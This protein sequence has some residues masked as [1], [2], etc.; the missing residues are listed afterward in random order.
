M[1]GEAG[2]PIDTNYKW[3]MLAQLWLTYFAFGMIGSSIPPLITPIIR[4]LTLSLSQMGIIL[5]TTHLI[6]IPMAILIGLL[7][8]RVGIRKSIL[9]GIA[10]VSLS[11]LL[12]SFATGFETLFLAV[13][14]QGLGGPTISV[15]L[16]KAVASWFV[17]KDRGTASGIYLTGYIMGV[18]TA[19]AITNTAIIPLVGTWR[20]ALAFYGLFGFLMGFVWLLFGREKARGR[21]GDVA[22]VS[23]RE[24][25]TVLLREKYVWMVAIIGFSS[26][27][28]RH[29][30]GGWLPKLLELKGMSPMRAGILASV[31]SWVGLFGSVVVP[32]L[33]KTGSRK[34]IISLALLVQGIC[35]FIIGTAAG[36]PFFASLFLYG[37]ST[38]AI[39]P[40]LMVVLMDLP[41]VGA[42]YMGVAG[43]L[44]FS[45]GE[46][47]GFLGPSMVGYL[48]DLTGSTLPGIIT[49][50]AVVEVM[51]I[52]A[53]LLREN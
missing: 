25:V 32:R 2:S 50:T 23:P 16:P 45:I 10:L 38:Y 41:P 15:G 35:V 36:T 42:E 52:F 27:F 17:G 26:F 29:S 19:T 1:N 30:F 40:L 33:G 31:P 7:I 3:L 51:L 11:G 9:A 53:L 24:A 6:Y 34:Y 5:G 8:D 12:R 21:A 47:G 48:L 43:G 39:L 44:F 46:V 49:L 28:V 20:N 14:L 22:S 18:A 37:I 4:D 13:C